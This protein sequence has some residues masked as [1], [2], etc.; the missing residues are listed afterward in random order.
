MLT[1]IHRHSME[2]ELDVDSNDVVTKEELMTWI[3]SS[4]LAERDAVFQV[5]D[6]NNPSSRMSERYSK[7]EVLQQ[8]QIELAANIFNYHDVSAALCCATANSGGDCGGGGA[9]VLVM[10]SLP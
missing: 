3:Q 8:L 4:Q 5:F 2:G 9:A 7:A 6:V 1:L 10:L